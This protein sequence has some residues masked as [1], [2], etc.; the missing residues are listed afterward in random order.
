M[1]R[2]YCSRTCCATAVKN[3][4]KIKELNPN[5]KI[6]ILY[7]D[8]RT[9]G[10]MESYYAKARNQGILFVKYEPEENR[11]SKVM[12]RVF[13]FLYG[14]NLKEKMEIKPDLLVLSVA[15][16]SRENEELATMLK[17]PETAEGFF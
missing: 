10:L 7:R 6:S 11:K 1:K 15:T 3:A 13:H 12:G 16:I 14:P 17:V 4:L 5:A 2:P 9:Y 8:V